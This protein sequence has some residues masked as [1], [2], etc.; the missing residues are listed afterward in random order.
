MNKQLFK[1]NALNLHKNS[2][3]LSHLSNNLLLTSTTPSSSASR[4]Y[5]LGIEG[6]SQED[7]I[8]FP[9]GFQARI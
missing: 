4:P 8:S 5:V 6:K 2:E 7:G 3:T 1:K 9:P